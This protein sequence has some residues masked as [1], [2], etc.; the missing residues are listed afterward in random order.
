VRSR[1]TRDGAL[2]I[3][4][5]VGEV[6]ADDSVN[7]LNGSKLAGACFSPSGR[8]LYFNPFGRARF[9]DDPVDGMTCTVTGPW[10][11]GPL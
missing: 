3:G 4:L 11:R 10:R 1:S 8:T 9:D 7:V 6:R 5:H 2:G